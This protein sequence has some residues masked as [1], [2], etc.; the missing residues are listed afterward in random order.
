MEEEREKLA[1]FRELFERRHALYEEQVQL[2]RERV[3]TEQRIRALEQREE[4]ERRRAERR[5]VSA[6]GSRRGRPVRI[7]VDE[8]AW[9]T[10]KREAVRRR[11]WLVWWIGDLIRIEVE[12]LVAGELSGSPSARRRRSPGEGHPQTR[13]RFL[14]I[15][16]DDEHWG[17]VRVA[18]VDVGLT[19]GRYVGE[20]A[21]ASAYE[22][23][24][25]S[26]APP[27]DGQS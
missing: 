1:R 27:R 11:L 25:R 3:R 13:Q 16:V 18:A 7:D 10:L 21:E 5:V 24:W 4:R 14:R 26:A 2:R 19:V 8:E 15:D 17:V 6:D 9:D 23:G 22:F 20:V 12:A